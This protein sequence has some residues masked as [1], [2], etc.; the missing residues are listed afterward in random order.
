MQRETMRSTC[1]RLRTLVWCQWRIRA[2]L[3]LGQGQQILQLGLE[4][5]HLAYWVTLFLHVG[6][7][8]LLFTKI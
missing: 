6:W 8:L 2:L 4:L 1:L 3:G 5:E 7:L